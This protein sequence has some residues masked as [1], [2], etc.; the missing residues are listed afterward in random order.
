ML[1][2]YPHDS[3][4]GKSHGVEHASR[5]LGDPRGSVAIAGLPGNRLRDQSS[6]TLEVKNS[7]QLFS[8]TGGPGS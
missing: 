2:P 1:F 3:R 6:E 5:K 8:E 7:V 4:I